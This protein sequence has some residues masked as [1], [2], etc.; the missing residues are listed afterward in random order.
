MY[1]RHDFHK[2][3]VDKLCLPT[4]YNK[5]IFFSELSGTL[6]LA[7]KKYENIL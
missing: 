6:N 4:P 1:R 5:D 7:R 2:C 3:L